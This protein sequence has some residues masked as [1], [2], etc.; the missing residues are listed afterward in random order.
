MSKKGRT[1][2][3]KIGYF[4]D[5]LEIPELAWENVTEGISKMHLSDTSGK[6]KNIVQNESPSSN[7]YIYLFIFKSGAF[8]LFIV[9]AKK[10]IPQTKI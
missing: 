10:K 4:C 6:R 2:G 1:E 7:I 3:Y 9:V 5:I 8:I